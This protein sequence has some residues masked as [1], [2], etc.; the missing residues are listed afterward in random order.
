MRVESAARGL[1]SLSFD[2]SVRVP[3]TGVKQLES[4]Y[5]E[6]IEA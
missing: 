5:L 6:E 1:E 4:E 2:F 3:G